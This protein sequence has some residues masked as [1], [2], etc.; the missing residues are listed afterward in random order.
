[1]KTFAF[2]ALAVLCIY[3]VIT[4]SEPKEFLKLREMY[5]RF[6]KILP[7]EFYQL[8]KKSVLVC[9][10]GKGELGYNVNKGY[11]IAICSDKDVNSMFHVLI[12]EL[13]HSSVP[14]YGHSRNFWKNAEKLTSLAS[15][16][17]LYHPIEHKKNYCGKTIRD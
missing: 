8:R 6:L 16:A 12:H 7:K 2:V 13:A 14:E 3:I 15:N 5:D 17:G 9:L 1:M 11:E 10:E 4:T